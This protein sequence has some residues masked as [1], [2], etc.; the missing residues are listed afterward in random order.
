MHVNVTG[1]DGN[2]TSLQKLLG[3]MKSNSTG[4]KHVNFSR[5]PCANNGEIQVIIAQNSCSFYRGIASKYYRKYLHLLQSKSFAVAA[6]V[7][8]K[9][10]NFFSS[11]I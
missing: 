5:Y 6:I 3:N 4:E 2:P 7:L 11:N 10:T 1:I 8:R 9:F